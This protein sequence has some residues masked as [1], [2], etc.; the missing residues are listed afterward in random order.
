VDVLNTIASVIEAG[1]KTNSYK[2]ALT[3]ALAEAHKQELSASDLA[4]R[5]LGYYW[6][7]A[8]TYRIRQSTDPFKEPVA[9]KWST[10]LHT[11]LKLDPG[12][13]LAKATQ[14]NPEEFAALFTRLSR[15][16]G[17]L[18]EVLPR[19]HVLHKESCTDPLFGVERLG[20]KINDQAWTQI[21]ANRKV[22]RQLAIGG[23]VRFCERIS[24]TPRM[25]LKLSSDIPK[26]K[27]LS[28]Y[29]TL[30]AKPAGHRCF[31]CDSPL[32][33]D[34]HVDHFLP[35]SFIL[36]DKLWNLVP[37]CGGD[38]GCNLRKSNRI[39]DKLLT[40]KL[41]D[42]NIRMLK[43]DLGVDLRDHKDL[44]E[45]KMWDLTRHIE[46]LSATALAEG[47]PLWQP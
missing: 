24:A 30:I 40:A 29:L 15:P 2:F 25:Y 16:G 10:E 13:S 11:S 38:N 42:R 17:C 19:F 7:L 14:A 5:F 43:G 4:E 21:T 26:R 46:Q 41:I 37:A 8:T 18:D 23:W 45:W 22:I 27:S 28:P 31:Y 20:I 3:L 39:P 36:E 12:I 44:R 33:T 6:P 9:Y 34:I 32:T 1:Q 47:F 35:W